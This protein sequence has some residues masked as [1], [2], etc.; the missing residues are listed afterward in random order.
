M[1]V[2]A[3]HEFP[4]PESYVVLQKAYVKALPYM[5]LRLTPACP[6]LQLDNAM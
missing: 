2:I 6:S 3:F 1:C 5:K 4:L